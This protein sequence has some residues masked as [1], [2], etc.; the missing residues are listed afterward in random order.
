MKKTI[1]LLTM[2]ASLL[3]AE[4]NWASSY[5]AAQ[6]Q[7]EK[8]G[9]LVMVM[10]SS[11]GCPACE[12]MKDIVFDEDSVIEE[13]HL[14]FVP[15]HVDIHNDFVPSGMGYIGTP[16]F[17]FVTAEGKKVGRLDGGANIPDFT[18]KMREV[19]KAAR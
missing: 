1:A 13:L 5:E 16:T 11:E 18:A 19:K 8:E 9:K 7:A 15:V 10:L 4:L 14:G 17:H 6:E 2:T 3:M 12:Y